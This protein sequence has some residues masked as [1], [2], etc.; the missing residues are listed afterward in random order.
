MELDNST[1]KRGQTEYSATGANPE[2]LGFAPKNLN[3]HF[4]SGFDSD[5]NNQY[6][7]FTKE[8][9]AQRA[10]DL[11]RSA[12]NDHILGYRAANGDIVRFDESTN[13]FVKCT[14]NGIRTMFQ[15]DEGTRYFERQMLR[16]GGVTYD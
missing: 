15:P 11:A 13:D 14:R 3:K 10:H 1:A 2:L 8:Q 5:H 16:D 12:V 6:P 9:Y 4:G 7:Q